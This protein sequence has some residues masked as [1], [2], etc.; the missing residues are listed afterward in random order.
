MTVKTH[1][2]ILSY[3]VMSMFVT[4]MDVICPPSLVQIL[5]NL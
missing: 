1:C 5:S 3:V 2:L 4:P